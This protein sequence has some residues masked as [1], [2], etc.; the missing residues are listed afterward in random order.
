MAAERGKRHDGGLYR[1]CVYP[2]RGDGL[3]AAGVHGPPGGAAP[4]AGTVSSLGAAGRRLRVGGLSSGAFL[5]VLD[6]GEDRIGGAAG[7]GGLRRG[8]E[9]GTAD[10]AV[11]CPLLRHGRVRAGIGASLRRRAHGGGRFL[12]GRGRPGAAHRRGGGL[13]RYDGG[14]PGGGQAGTGGAAPEGA[15]VPGGSGG[16]H[17]GPPRHR[18]CPA[19]SR[20]RRTGAGDGT[21]RAGERSAVPG[22]ADP[23]AGAAALP[24]GPAGAFAGGG[25][26]A[27]VFPGAIPDGGAAG[28]T[29]ADGAQRLDGGGGD[30]VPGLAG[31]DLR[32]RRGRGLCRFV[33]RQCND[34]RAT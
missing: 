27:A 31:G 3:S 20:L 33:G 32:R 18:E 6:A 25:A 14:V 4:A 30:T 13:C 16:D 21:G 26:A 12:Y 2:Q 1:Q 8:G 19:P 10:A 15:G 29:A 5:P 7:S 11:F 24:G 23:D 17:D 28:G 34:G 9:A 22:A